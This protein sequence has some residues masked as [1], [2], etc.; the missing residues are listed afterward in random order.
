MYFSS[1]LVHLRL[2]F[3]AP[4]LRNSNFICSGKGL[5]KIL[6]DC[7]LY[8]VPHSMYQAYC[9]YAVCLWAFLFHLLVV[10]GS[11]NVHST[12]IQH[13]YAYSFFGAHTSHITLKSPT[14]NSCHCS[15][16]S[17]LSSLSPHCPIRPLLLTSCC[18]CDVDDKAFH[19][20]F[21]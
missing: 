5:Y 7:R 17:S 20:I 18:V 4:Q 8:Y 12:N 6:A 3:S 13:T 2:S 16:R 10:D 9:I 15:F 11:I 19:I 14:P 1:C 21:S